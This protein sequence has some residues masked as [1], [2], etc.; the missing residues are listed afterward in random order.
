MRTMCF[1]VVLLCPVLLRAATLVEDG[2]A[3]SAILLPAEPN[4]LETIAADELTVHLEKMSGA[5]LETL[6]VANDELAR[7]VKSLQGE[8]K[9]PILLGRLA[10]VQLQARVRMASNLDGAFALEVRP[11]L[12]SVAGA[13]DGA[14]FG[15]YEALEQLGVRWFMPGELGAVIPSTKTIQLARQETIQAPS[16]TGRY[17]QMNGAPADWLRRLRCGGAPQ[18]PSAHGLPGLG[19]GVFKE[20]PEYFA[21]IDGERSPRQ[22]C[23]S[24]PHVLKIVVGEVKE[25]AVKNADLRVV[26]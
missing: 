1:A 16:F 11:D 7:T 12:V 13:G 19:R 8:G 4:E 21:L 2:K 23:L 25:R 10:P 17:F 26:G 22:H 5:K 6:L 15:V 18:F 14:V 24:N 20:H 9:T 3:T